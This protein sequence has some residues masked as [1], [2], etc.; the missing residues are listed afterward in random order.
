LCAHSVSYLNRVN[1]HMCLLLCIACLYGLY[2]IAMRVYRFCCVR[3][4]VLLNCFHEVCYREVVCNVASQGQC[5]FVVVMFVN[6][7]DN[8]VCGCVACASACVV[9][10]FADAMYVYG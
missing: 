8:C 1:I 6:K 7:V 9:D 3:R 2:K 10:L 5:R 4:V